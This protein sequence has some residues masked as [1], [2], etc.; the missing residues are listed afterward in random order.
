MV[1][2]FF[3][4][5][6][7]PSSL[8]Q[9]GSLELPPATAAAPANPSRGDLLELPPA[10][11]PNATAAGPP[12]PDFAYPATAAP[13]GGRSLYSSV[14]YVTGPHGGWNKYAF[15]CADYGYCF[16]TTP[17]SWIGRTTGTARRRL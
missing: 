11:A 1:P 8:G 15:P 6:G 4:I 7:L 12:L 16:G 2:C 10:F 14:P 9:G 17:I 13:H 5:I 3:L